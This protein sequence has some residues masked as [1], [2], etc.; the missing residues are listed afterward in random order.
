MALTVELL[1]VWILVFIYEQRVLGFKRDRD[2]CPEVIRNR[3]DPVSLLDDMCYMYV[4]EE[5]YWDQARDY[6]WNLGGELVSIENKKTMNHIMAKFLNVNG[7]THSKNGVWIG[8]KYND[9]TKVWRWTTGKKLHYGYWAS[10]QPSQSVI[11]ISFEDCGIMRRSDGWRWH[12]YPCHLMRYTYDFICQFPIAGGEGV[13]QPEQHIASDTVDNGNTMILGIIIGTGIFILLL[14]ILTFLI[15][16]HLQKKKYSRE[17]PASNYGNENYVDTN[18]YNNSHSTAVFHNRPRNDSDVYLTPAEVNTLYE[19]V[20]KP[21]NHM[22]INPNHVTCPL[23]VNVPNQNRN[24]VRQAGK[25]SSA[26]SVVI[27]GAS[28]QADTPVI[29]PLPSTSTIPSIMETS[30][31]SVNEYVDMASGVAIPPLPDADQVASNVNSLKNQKGSDTNGCAKRSAGS[32]VY[33]NV[34]SIT[35]THKDSTGIYED[36]P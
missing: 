3:P 1:C 27:S 4:G 28:S 29:P 13:V 5:K 24:N 16:R 15:Y 26:E 35:S 34:D 30:T 17:I 6:C 11:G 25:G 9:N 10:G 8:A 36:I 32:P 33:S 19:E 14:V 23:I 31:R 22:I 12:D 20:N 2:R 18:N 21:A 7:G